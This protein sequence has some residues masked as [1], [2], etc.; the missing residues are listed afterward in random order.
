MIWVF[1]ALFLFFADEELSGDFFK[2]LSFFIIFATIFY[3]IGWR[4]NR[5]LKHHDE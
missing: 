2:A 4:A 3:T 1:A 5:K